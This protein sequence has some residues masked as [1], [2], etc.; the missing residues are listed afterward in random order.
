MLLYHFIIPL[1][2]MTSS[3][4]G[5]VFGG[6][7]GKEKGEGLTMFNFPFQYKLGSQSDPIFTHIWHTC[8]Q[9]MN[10]QSRFSNQGW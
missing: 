7:A 1:I 2:I 9:E 8:V 5:G 4:V 3:S 6:V 10:T